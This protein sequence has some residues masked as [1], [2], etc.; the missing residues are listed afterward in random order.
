MS[1]YAN[2]L[3]GGALLS[4]FLITTLPVFAYDQKNTH[5]ALTDEIVD[6]YNLSFPGNK[7]S[8]EDKK[9]LIQGSI[10]EDHGERPL[11]HFYDPVYNRGIAGGTSSKQWALASGIQANYYN[12]RFAGLI[13]LTKKDSDA[14][15]SYERALRDFANGDKER[16]FIAWR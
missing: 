12:S 11:F 6:F 5:P 8:V 13:A 15:F 7:L 9:L 2:I 3:K 1:K 4:V 10:D 16:S 14:D